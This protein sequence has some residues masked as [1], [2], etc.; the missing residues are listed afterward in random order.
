M[1]REAWC[2]AVHGVTKSWTWLSHWTELNWNELGKPQRERRVCR[3]SIL[4]IQFFYKSRT[5]VR[6]KTI[7]WKKNKNGSKQIYNKQNIKFPNKGRTFRHGWGWG[8]G[9]IIFRAVQAQYSTLS[10]LEESLEVTFYFLKLLCIYLLF[11][12]VLGLHRCLWT[13]SGCCAWA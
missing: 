8:D 6:A 2:A 11:L 12:A 4:S 5:V 1:Y 3:N 13:F 10:E 9:G 7:N